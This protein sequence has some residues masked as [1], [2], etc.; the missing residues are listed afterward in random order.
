[1][2]LDTLLASLA[3]GTLDA[4]GRR[5]L[6]AIVRDDPVARR[7]YV[8]HCQMHALLKSAHG[9]L[10]ALEPRNP[11][12]GLLATAAGLLLAV[13][14]FALWNLQRLSEQ[15][16]DSALS[17]SGEA[18]I[19]RGSARVTAAAAGDL[20]DGDRIVTGPSSAAEL[21]APDGTRLR[22]HE[23]G[24]AR[25]HKEHVVLNAGLLRGDVAPREGALVLRTSQAEARVLGT[26]FELSASGTETRLNLLKGLMKLSIPGQ[27]LRVGAGEL[28]TTDGRQITKWVPVCRFDFAGMRQI[29]PGFESV[30]CLSA[31]LHTPER[32]VVPAPD[33]VHFVPE[34]LVLGSSSPAP[35]GLRVLRW[36][37]ETGE[38]LLM[39]VDVAGGDRWS[40]GFALG[41]DSFEGFRVIFA[42]M[43]YPQG[44]TIDTIHP[45]ATT[46]FAADPRPVHFDRDHTLRAER[47][48]SRFRVW[49]DR[50]L[51]LDTQ[52]THALPSGRKRTFALSNFGL[53]PVVKAL[54]VWRP[55]R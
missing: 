22:L 11:R 27:E 55:E 36:L 28:A 47:S 3:E 2:D 54:R 20:R 29:P 33:Y 15:R 26:S 13:S 50:E 44:I 1:M 34:G 35:H 53:P 9:E 6:S 30:F 43:E 7:R 45:V 19:Q 21:R 48:G 5:R 23:D 10:R 42:V 8:E 46:I 12:V 40:L 51:R 31:P 32:K 37:E 49:V 17:S 24:D 52:I 25:F 41:G 16:L 14:G 38:D 39:E 18:W 4:A